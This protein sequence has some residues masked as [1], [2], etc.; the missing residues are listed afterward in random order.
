MVKIKIK[1]YEV[2]IDVPNH[3]TISAQTINHQRKILFEG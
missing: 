3:Q 1:Y 2:S